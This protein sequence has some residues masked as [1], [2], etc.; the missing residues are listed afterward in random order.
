MTPHSLN[1]FALSKIKGIGPAFIKRN[2]PQI[3][4]SIHDLDSL[5]SLAPKINKDEF[6]EILNSCEDVLENADNQKI[7]VIS[8]VDNDY[9]KNL[10]ELKDPP[11]VIFLRG[12]IENLEKCIAIIGTRKS[13]SLGEK[14]A[15]R[16]GEFFCQ[17]WSI[18]NGLVDGIDK[19]S[20]QGESTFYPNVTGVLSGGLNFSKT[21]SKT[22]QNLANKVLENSGL[23]ISEFEPDQKEDQFSGSKASRIQAGLSLGLIL[24]QSSLDGGSKYTLKAFSELNRVLG[25]IEFRGNQEYETSELFEANRKI[26]SEKENGIAKMISANGITNIRFKEILNIAKKEDYKLFEDAILKKNGLFG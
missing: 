3:K 20:I 15:S 6:Q 12:K 5:L 8:I 2:L 13:S 26:I 25:I 18:C 9:P 14:I 23:L 4:S 1:V 17:N 19:H 22:T 16:I 24:I 7:K 11:P 21:C 10:L